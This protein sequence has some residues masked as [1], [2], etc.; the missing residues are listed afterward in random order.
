MIVLQK[1]AVHVEGHTEIGEDRKNNHNKKTGAKP[2]SKL[3]KKITG[4]MKTKNKRRSQPAN[5]TAHQRWFGATR[6]NY[7]SYRQICIHP[8]IIP[9]G[10]DHYF[11]DI[12]D[13]PNKSY[14]V[15]YQNLGGFPTNYTMQTTELEEV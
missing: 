5:Q 12:R 6:K 14:R 1:E 2:K 9:Q 13:P 15:F 8:T 3:K 11:G 10:G 7:Q 4:P